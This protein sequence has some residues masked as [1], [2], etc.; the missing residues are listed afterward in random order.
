MVVTGSFI[1]SSYFKVAP[2]DTEK[3]IHQTQAAEFFA[4][5][6]SDKRYLKSL[7]NF[8]PS[9]LGADSRLS[10]DSVT[11]KNDVTELPERCIFHVA[12]FSSLTMSLA[13]HVVVNTVNTARPSK[14]VEGLHKATCPSAFWESSNNT[15]ANY[16]I[17]ILLDVFYMLQQR[18]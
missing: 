16:P 1:V 13:T 4:H 18:M 10:E 17:P 6:H 12:Q 5:K 9:G 15:E 11:T 7:I 8:L 3:S 2:T 14:K